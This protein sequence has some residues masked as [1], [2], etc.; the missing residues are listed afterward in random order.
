MTC[1]VTTTN[2]LLI[3]VLVSGSLSPLLGQTCPQTCAT[4]CGP[5]QDIDN[6]TIY[7]KC[8]AQCQLKCY[9]CQAAVE[10]VSPKYFV[11]G[12][13][14][15]PPG[16]TST[17]A[18]SCTTPSTVDYLAGSTM[19]TKVSMEHAFESSV[20]FKFD[21][22]FNLGNDAKATQIG[23]R[24]SGGYS[25]TPS[26]TNST[27]ISKTNTLEIKATGNADGVNHDQD[28]FILLLNPAIAIQQIPVF[29]TEQQCISAGTL[30]WYFGVNPAALNGQAA[31]YN[32][33]V[34]ELK[35][36][37]SMPVDVA[38]QLQ[39]LKFTND[40]FQTILSLD[41]FA[42]GSTAID[43]TRFSP[44][45]TGFPYEPTPQGAA[46]NNGKCTC[47]SLQQAIKN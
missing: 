3:L 44:T 18:Q 27:T 35:N 13:V 46:C 30:N 41:P 36:P 4:S 42:N 20:D 17:A 47:L 38:Q 9:K 1:R 6:K 22:S 29:N 31:R 19:G 21:A 23:A 45:T 15:S 39:A 12:L 26:D 33:S 8:L 7:N 32:L 40:D 14:Y 25:D 16:C 5:S 2:L 11:L 10:A 28:E 24:A 43:P 34:G 37:Q